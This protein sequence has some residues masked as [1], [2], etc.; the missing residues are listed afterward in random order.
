[1]YIPTTNPSWT[2][3]PPEADSSASD[4]NDIFFGSDLFSSNAQFEPVQLLQPS[5][6]ILFDGNGLGNVDFNTEPPAN[7]SLEPFGMNVPSKVNLP[8]PNDSQIGA[9]QPELGVASMMQE[10]EECPGVPVTTSSTSSLLIC[11][12]VRMEDIQPNTSPRSPDARV[13][14][15]S[16][17]SQPH[18]RH[19]SEKFV[20]Q[21]RGYQSSFRKMAELR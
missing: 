21:W 7:Q 5:D 20:C 9:E 2:P 10:S 17:Q 13:L 15:V 4:L 14:Q 3:P 12:V 19:C 11:D 16:V 18:V 1:V 8:H 6:W